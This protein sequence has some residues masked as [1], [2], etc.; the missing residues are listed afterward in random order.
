[1][2]KPAPKSP[3]SVPQSTAEEIRQMREAGRRIAASKTTARRFLASIGMH[4]SN[5]Q[6]KP[7][8]R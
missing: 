5:G 7:Q 8:F 3:A 4:Q 1:M 2:S 6:L